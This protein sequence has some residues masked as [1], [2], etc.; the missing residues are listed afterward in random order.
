MSTPGDTHPEHTPKE[1]TVTTLTVLAEPVRWLAYKTLRSL[2]P[3]R[4][5]VLARRL[6]VSEAVMSQHL[7]E[8]RKIDFVTADITTDD[9]RPT[10]RT[11][12]TAVPGGV[13]IGRAD[14]TGEIGRAIQRWMEV[15]AA[16][17][18]MIQEDWVTVRPGWPGEWRAA[19]EDTDYLLSL[20]V[21]ELE[22]LGNEVRA[23][24]QRYRDMCR[25]RE[26]TDPVDT[27]CRP[28]HAAIHIHPWPQDWA[29]S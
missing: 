19:A 14:H 2:G 9:G 8:L 16:C 17:T 21:E 29:D 12:W 28:V 1:P 4:A 24:M 15:D 10:R 22:A 11:T 27:A 6:K 3:Q 23:I 18:G 25:D 5:S 26:A 20:T 13:F 7:Q